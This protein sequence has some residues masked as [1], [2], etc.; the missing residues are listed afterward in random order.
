MTNIHV[1]EF[2]NPFF[3]NAC[4]APARDRGDFNTVD[5]DVMNLNVSTLRALYSSLNNGIF[6]ETFVQ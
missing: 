1:P 2:I 4:L 5:I 3:K 6:K